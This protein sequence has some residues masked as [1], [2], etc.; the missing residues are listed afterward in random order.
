LR[1]LASPQKQKKKKKKKRVS[2][3]D[4]PLSSFFPPLFPHF[5]FVFFFFF[6]RLG[7]FF[8]VRRIH[9]KNTT[10]K[11]SKAG[12]FPLLKEPAEGGPM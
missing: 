7:G 5:L 8:V 10:W 9:P 3:W 1:V 12:N 4:F 11:R 2:G 6:P